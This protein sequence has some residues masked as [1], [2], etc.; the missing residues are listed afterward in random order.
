MKKGNWSILY[1]YNLRIV[2]DIF[3]YCARKEKVFMPDIYA[4]MAKGIIAPP[5]DKW[6]QPQRKKKDRLGLEYVHAVDYLGF[7]RKANEF[8]IP[9][10]SEFREEKKA[11]LAENSRRQFKK[12][13][14]VSPP[15]TER[16]KKALLP[17]VLNYER[18][19]DFLH[20]FLDF[21]K[22][23][24]IYSFNE[25][26]FRKFAEPIFILA[27]VNK[28]KKGS[29][30]LR[31]D[32]DN[33]VW[34]IPD[35]YSRIASYLF[36]DWFRDLGLIDEVIVFP[37]F[38]KDQKLWHMYYAIKISKNDFLKLQFNPL[39]KQVF[40]EEKKKRLWIPYLIY[41]IA[42]KYGCP[43]VAIKSALNNLYSESQE[44]F[45]LERVSMHLM[46]QK[47]KNSYVKIDG[48]FRS[49]ILY[50]EVM[51]NEQEK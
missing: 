14:T 6:F 30:F 31:R 5:R 51:D 37:E 17:I 19:R 3:V 1:A 7:V 45:Y 43:V 34:K 38:S 11:I 12:R 18:A 21:E 39:L 47:Y 10:F 42:K 23:K 40:A 28:G 16:E 46:K 32:S 22:F 29:E 26:T 25:I 24:D 48:F 4:D 2:R 35:E 13:Q 15:F 9:D 36:P 20:W 44:E 41:V 8:L 33:Y 50:D 27:K 49:Y